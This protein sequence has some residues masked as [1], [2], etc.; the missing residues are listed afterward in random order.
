MSC[1]AYLAFSKGNPEEFILALLC[2]QTRSLHVYQSRDSGWVTFS[3]CSHPWRAMDLVVLHQRVYVIT[4]TAK[5]GVMKLHDGTVD[6]LELNNTPKNFSSIN[7]KLVS[8]D[9][10]LLVVHFDRHEQMFAV[11]KIDFSRMEWVK[12]EELGDIALF[13][14][15]RRKCYALSN[16]GKWGYDKEC[17]YYINSVSAECI[18]YSMKKELIKCFDPTFQAPPRSKLY[19]LD[20]CFLHVRDEIDY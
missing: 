19:W 5:L 1:H 15:V 3:R 2:E 12:V 11:Y 7:H 4:D 8:S 17:V 14:S 16:P 6:F 10:N 18:V 20:W 13:I 9:G